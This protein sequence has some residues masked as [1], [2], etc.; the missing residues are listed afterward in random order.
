MCGQNVKA[1]GAYSNN[2]CVVLMYFHVIECDVDGVWIGNRIYW[3][4]EHNSR[5]KFTTQD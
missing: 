3:T 4:I 2:N 5:I 1:G